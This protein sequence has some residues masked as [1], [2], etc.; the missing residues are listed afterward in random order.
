LGCQRQFVACALAGILTGV[1]KSTAWRYR[2]GQTEVT[3]RHAHRCLGATTGVDL[4]ELN[5]RWNSAWKGTEQGP[6]HYYVSEGLLY[7][8]EA[9]V[10]QS[11]VGVK[12]I[13]LPRKTKG[14]S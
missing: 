7:F 13:R 6:G 1:S 8:R 14:D 3:Y 12:R 4:Q 11:R 9:S 2:H 10:R 5:E